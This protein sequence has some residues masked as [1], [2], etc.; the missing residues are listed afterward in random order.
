MPD[1]TFT[2]DQIR[3]GFA[4][5]IERCKGQEWPEASDPNIC[6]DYLVEVMKEAPDA[7]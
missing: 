6:A 5:W 7:R 4:K 1:D 2:R 3:D